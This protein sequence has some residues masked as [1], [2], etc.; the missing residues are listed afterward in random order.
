MGQDIFLNFL[1]YLVPSLSRVKSIYEP[2]AEDRLF[3]QEDSL[4]LRAR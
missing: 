1:R 3:P 2:L 4:V